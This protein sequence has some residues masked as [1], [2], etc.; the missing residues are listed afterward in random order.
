MSILASALSV[1]AVILFMVFYFLYFSVWPLFKLRRLYA[2]YKN[3]FSFRE[4]NPILGDA[5]RMLEA[6]SQQKKCGMHY[7]L[8][9]FE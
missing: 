1:V 6:V 3:V 2:N 5:P 7:F 8:Q 9:E 4:N